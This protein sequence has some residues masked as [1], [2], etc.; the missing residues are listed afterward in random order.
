MSAKRIGFIGLGDMGM[1][2]AKNLVK[3][4]YELTVCGHVRREGIEAIKEM[5]AREVK[6]PREVARASDL[7]IS[8]VR[9]SAQ[10]NEVMYGPEGTLA[11]LQKGSIVVISSTLYPGYCQKLAVEIGE[12]GAGM[13]D[14]PVS[15][16][17][18]GSEAGTLTF[19]VGG[20]ET[21]FK[22]CLP[23]FQAMGKNIFHVGGVGTGQVAKLVNNLTFYINMV[24]AAEGLSLGLKAGLKLE[25]MLEVIKASTGNSW[26][27]QNYEM[28]RKQRVNSPGIRDLQYN[29]MDNALTYAREL[30][31]FAI[32]IIGL[33]SQSDLSTLFPGDEGL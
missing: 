9:D 13:L 3:H 32:P 33:L 28:L 11:G 22:E 21:L 17:H 16:A 14:A 6:T 12:K 1:G 30:K 5:G 7:I 23:V 15:G 27:V 24:A 8:I 29:T 19:M 31:I 25:R 20:E 18:I 26:V 2:M 4:R 10:T